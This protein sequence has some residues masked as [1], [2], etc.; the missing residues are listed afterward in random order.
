METTI[1]VSNGEA[2]AKR[3]LFLAWKAAR[4]VGMG[5]LADR[6]PHMTEEQV[7]QSARTEKGQVFADYVFGRM[8]KLHLRYRETSVETNTDELRSDYQS[9]CGVYRNYGELV[10]AAERELAA[11][12]N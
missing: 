12:G 6:G 4:V 3:A 11:S 2:V 10:Q 5:A 1:N 9:W 7:W 8:M